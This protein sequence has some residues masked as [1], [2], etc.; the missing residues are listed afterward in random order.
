M[1][2]ELFCFFILAFFTINVVSQR[3][4]IYNC[5]QKGGNFIF[6]TFSIQVSLKYSIIFVIDSPI[7]KPNHNASMNGCGSYNF[8][9]KFEKFDF[10]FSKCCNVHDVW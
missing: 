4:C 9:F 2:R 3:S 6:L 1:K 10:N 7:S 8:T 5:K